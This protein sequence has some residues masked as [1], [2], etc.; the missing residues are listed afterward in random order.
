MGQEDKKYSILD[1]LAKSNGYEI[2]LM[3]TFNFEIGFFERAVLN[4]LYTCDVKKVSLFVDSKELNK[5]LKDI[6]VCYL[7]K[8][9]MVTPVEMQGSFHPKVILLLG[10]RKAK[11]FV[12]SANI[13]TSGY[14]INNEIFNFIEYS[15][16]HTEYLD[17]INAAI[18]FFAAINETT[19]GIDS[20]IIKEAKSQIYYH[21][22]ESNGECFFFNNMEDSIL[23]QANKLI[24]EDINEVRIAVPYYDNGLAAFS[25]LK[26]AYDK[27]RIRLYLQ[28]KKSTFP[29]ALNDEKKLTEDIELFSGFENAGANCCDNFYHGKVFLFK[30]T[31]HD[32]IMYGSANCTQSALVKSYEQGGNV[33][34]D[35]FEIGTP[36]EFDYFFDGMKFI[37]GKEPECSIMVHESEDTGNFFFRYGKLNSDVELHIGYSNKKENLK[38]K[39]QDFELKY[40]YMDKDIVVILPEEYRTAITDVFDICFVYDGFSEAVRCWYFN[41]AE[42][43]NYRA[44]QSDKGSLDSFDIDA[45]GDKF[46]EDRINLLKA[47]LTSSPE[48]LEYKKNVAIDN[49]I[50]QELEGDDLESQDEDFIVDVP[51]TDEYR[52]SY[53]QYNLVAK[54]RRQFVRQFLLGDSS[55][56][57]S[58]SEEGTSTSTKGSSDSD[59]T[60]ERKARQATTAEKRFERFVKGKVKGMLND[61]YVEII[62]PEHYL[63][64]IA[65]VL[66]IFDKYNN[67]ELVKDIFT[68]EYVIDTRLQFFSKIAGKDLSSEN[69]IVDFQESIIA[70]CFA[71]IIDNHMIVADYQDREVARKIESDNRALLLQLE[72]K[73]VLRAIYPE[74]IKKAIT[75]GES[76][77]C[78]LGKD[79][80][81]QYIE[82]LYDYK[83]LDMLA[84]FIQSKYENA[85][86]ELKGKYLHIN[87]TTQDMREHHRPLLDVLREIGKYSRNVFP[88]DSVSINIQ[89][90][91]PNPE[92]KNIIVHIKHYISMSYHNWRA[93]ETRL[94]GSKYDSKSQFIS[95]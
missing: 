69:E 81:C 15:S 61:K 93:T 36:G 48:F 90:V 51:I 62:E 38:I 91:A 68:T 29:V 58:H 30:G 79:K 35:F 40:Q 84:R 44:K 74:F 22:S 46:V 80:A 21:K 18:D 66:D 83:N 55:V 56:F 33:E 50:K 12:G 3:T 34:C 25:A 24:L 42:I 86:I 16:E 59:T 78:T 32:Y 88:V 89:N 72:K 71:V 52:S 73:Y 60:G 95:F 92:N 7:G 54:I 14:A 49:Q 2:A 10:K 85:T 67:A 43:E 87:A 28:D 77:V 64:I 63:G 13:K 11:L 39:L 6:S 45:N 27:A 65:V 1:E 75:Q 47:E 4:R 41:S 26:N 53:R 17:V 23:S 5:A 70:K 76:S 20:S 9:Y 57:K 94:D 8:R 19:I 82:A 31:S 37:S